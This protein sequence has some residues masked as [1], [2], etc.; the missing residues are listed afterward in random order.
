M[1]PA[2]QVQFVLPKEGEDHFLP[3]DVAD[4]PL[5]LTPEFTGRLRV[6][7][8]QIAEQAFVGNIGGSGNFVDLTG[9][10]ELGRETS[11]HAENFA[12]DEGWDRKA[13]EAVDEVFPQFDSI[14]IFALF[15]ETIYAGDGG[16]F[17]VTSE[18]VD[19]IGEFGFEGKEEADCF[20]TLTTPVDVIAQKEV[21]AIGRHATVL[22]QSQ[23]IVV[24][25]MDISAYF[26]GCGYLE[27]HGLFHKDVFD[28]FDETCNLV[29]G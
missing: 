11:V 12:L 26:D 22:E 21:A 2:D 1:S 13:V 14:S 17:V 16:G 3:E 27:K 28:N 25:A 18:D 10:N 5:W 8:K 6:G 9:L 23:H 19:F 24:L 15:E 20:D 7:P 4:S 29:L